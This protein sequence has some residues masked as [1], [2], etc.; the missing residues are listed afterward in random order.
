MEGNQSVTLWADAGS[1]NEMPLQDRPIPHF[2]TL[3]ASEEDEGAEP[4]TGILKTSV[5]HY[6]V[7]RGDLKTVIAGYP[8]FLDW[9]RD[10]LIFVRGLVAAGKM[11]AARDIVT[12]RCR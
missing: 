6:V 7:K 12:H 9:G 2:I 1:E 4:L 10:A 5:D 8:W 3:A 11:A